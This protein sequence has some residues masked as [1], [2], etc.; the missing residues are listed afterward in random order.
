MFGDVSNAGQEDGFCEKCK[1]FI[2]AVDARAPLRN[3]GTP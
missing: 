1:P 2:K 3:G